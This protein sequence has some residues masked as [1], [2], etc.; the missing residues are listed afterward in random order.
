M[1][2]KSAG[3]AGASPPF[4]PTHREFN[5]QLVD[6][7]REMPL[8]TPKLGPCD[9]TLLERET[10]FRTSGDEPTPSSYLSQ[11]PAESLKDVLVIG[12]IRRPPMIQLIPLTIA[13]GCVF[14]GFYW[15]MRD[16]LWRG[17]GAFGYFFLFCA[18]LGTFGPM[19]YATL[20]PRGRLMPDH[21][22]R[23]DRA[24]GVLSYLGGAHTFRRDE[25][26][27]LIALTA[28]GQWG[29]VSELQ[30]VAGSASPF[31]R[32][33]VIGTT[34]RD[35]RKVFGPAMTAMQDF[36]GIPGYVVRFTAKEPG[37]ELESV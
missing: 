8:R 23:Y 34:H 1:V 10:S 36:A 18:I 16:L 11:L 29:E 7:V 3:L 13:I 9:V 19:A 25:V 4:Y 2:L 33:R 22:L 21:L 37:F 26:V 30:I 35:A 28:R 20:M 12:Q 24:T 27:C 6:L 17:N 32:V 15:L 14:V 31:R 5:R